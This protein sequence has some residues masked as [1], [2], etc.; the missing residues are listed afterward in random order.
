MRDVLVS[1]KESFKIEV[2]F[3]I[4]ETGRKGVKKPLIVFLHGFK[5]KSFGISG[6]I[7]TI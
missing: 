6:I 1:G 4:T 7:L 2:P 3:K 5:Q